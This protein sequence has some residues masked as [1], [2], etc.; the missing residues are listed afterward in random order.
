MHKYISP[1]FWDTGEEIEEQKK[2][3][4]S[5]LVRSFTHEFVKAIWPPITFF[6]RN[7]IYVLSI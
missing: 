1:D 6:S 5:F 3:L 2:I 4:P 7:R